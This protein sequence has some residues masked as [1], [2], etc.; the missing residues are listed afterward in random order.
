MAT[1]DETP[2]SI[3]GSQILVYGLNIIPVAR[4][5]KY[6]SVGTVF[7][8]DVK[9]RGRGTIEQEYSPKK[10]RIHAYSLLNQGDSISGRILWGFSSFP[11]NRDNLNVGQ[12]SRSSSHSGQDIRCRGTCLLEII[13]GWRGAPLPVHP[14]EA[15]R[16]DSQA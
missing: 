10:W 14:R 5:V 9:Q 6:G 2:A 15:L 12:V 4:P 11:F 7:P 3:E 8:F 16:A 13:Q 1:K